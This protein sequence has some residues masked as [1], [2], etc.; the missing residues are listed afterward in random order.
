MTYAEHIQRL[1]HLI[2]A[3]ECVQD[4]AAHSGMQA[5][6]MTINKAREELLK[7][8]NHAASYAAEHAAHGEQIA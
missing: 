3:I 4:S 1:N 6:A 5:A 2:A 8:R 7:D